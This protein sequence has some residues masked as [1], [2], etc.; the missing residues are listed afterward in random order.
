ML[1]LTRHNVSVGRAERGRIPP[2]VLAI[3]RAL[4]VRVRERRIARN[5][6]VQDYGMVFEKTGAGCSIVVP[7][8]NNSHPLTI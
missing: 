7:I 1:L 4:H 3:V 5:C 2:Y 6:I 8:V